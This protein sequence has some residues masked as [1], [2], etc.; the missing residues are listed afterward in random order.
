MK[1]NMIK[2]SQ[3]YIKECESGIITC[4]FS[5]QDNN[6]FPV[7]VLKDSGYFKNLK[8]PIDGKN[9]ANCLLIEATNKNGV[10][11]TNLIDNCYQ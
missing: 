3:D 6:T 7:S 4:N 11:I 9:L 8:S 5:W 10:I 1:N 2:A